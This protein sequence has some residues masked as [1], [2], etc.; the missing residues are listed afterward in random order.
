M[1]K[2]YFKIAWRNIKSNSLYSSINIGGLSLGIAASLLVATVVINELSYDKHW[3]KS[4]R[5]V[6]INQEEPETG[7]KRASTPLPLAPTLA[8]NFDQVESFSNIESINSTFLFNQDKIEVSTLEVNPGIWNILDLEI[9]DGEPQNFQ[10]GY[11][12]LVITQTIKN[13]YFPDKNPVGEIVENV[14]NF[15]DN[16]KFIITGII[17]DLPVN[18][19]LRAEALVINKSITANFSSNG[20]MPYGVQYLLLKNGVS[21]IAFTQK[22]NQ[23]Y[24]DN[25]AEER[26]LN[27]SLQPM[28][29]IYLNSEGIY[30]K[31][32]GNR[33]H[34]N[35]LIGVAI[36]LLLIASI[37]FVNLSTARTIEK[38][39]TTGLRKILGASRKGLIFQF[40]IESFLFFS[41]SFVIGLIIY[42]LSLAPLEN[43]IGNALALNFLN[44]AQLLVSAL[45]LLT[46]VSLITGLYPAWTISRPGSATVTSSSFQPPKGSEI[47]RKSLIV[48]QFIITV[49]IIVGTLVVNNQLLYLNQK[50]LGF[51][52]ENLLWISFTNWGV[53]G[54]AFKK[55]I[56]NIPGV[57]TAT[58][59]QWIPSSGGTFSKN[60]DDPQF[61]GNQ[62]ETWYIDGDQ[63]FQ[64]TLQLEVL[65]GRSFRQEFS[66]DKALGPETS[67]AEEID[68]N[69]NPVLITAYT[70]KRLKINELNRPHEAINGIPIGIV[71][72]FHNQSLRNPLAPTIIRSV[73]NP[74]FGNMLIRINTENPMQIIPKLEQAYTSFYPE[75]RFD[76]SWISEHLKREFEKEATISR[77]LKIFSTL[78][79]L[80]SCLGLF[81]LITFN[82]QKRAKEIS[83]RKVLGASVTQ[84]VA[85]FSK[86]SLKLIVVASLISVPLA[87]YFLN[88]WLADF[89][90]RIEIS[91]LIFFESILIVV[92]IALA[93]ISVKVV[94]AALRNPA[95]NLRTE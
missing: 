24:A 21:S 17:E 29:D 61:P 53:N 5:I 22:I 20:F 40:L 76:F 48:T 79:I 49:G 54:S 2:N 90:Y 62:L 46:V 37:N 11:P 43:F 95:K 51:E 93:T 47:F 75:N 73:K 23:W 78:I 72:D 9:K 88:N 94:K 3:S 67:E 83:I 32:K 59:G 8:D 26:E 85:I 6:R 70:A 69:L 39:K 74:E 50:D 80:L 58:I 91:P 27:F 87:W 12:N 63:D 18:S 10:P 56:T 81:G 19:H 52:K 89:P 36:F 30:Q 55:E 44:Q 66:A 71:K 4:D 42:F 14:S 25:V 45:F 1:F 15:G 68:Q 64:S 38:I 35:I 33:N 34:I 41:I 28:D 86:D 16:E 84:I 13:R 65:E 92:V 57:E 77:I 82:L 60:V 7:S 31:V